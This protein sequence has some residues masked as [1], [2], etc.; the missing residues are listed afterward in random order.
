MDKADQVEKQVRRVGRP[1]KVVPM[2]TYVVEGGN[3]EYAPPV[4][5]EIPVMP[6]ITA[7]QAFAKAVWDAQSPYEPRAWRLM[8]VAEAMKN[9]GFSMEG[10]VL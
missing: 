10:I 2:N 4:V 9:K 7:E 5:L 8:R 3:V 1:R 6:D